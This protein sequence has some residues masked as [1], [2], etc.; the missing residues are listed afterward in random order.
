MDELLPR[1]RINVAAPP[2][3]LASL[4]DGDIDD[5]HLEIGF[6]AGEHLVAN[7]LAHPRRGCIG[8]E[9]FVHGLSRAV[10]D[11]DRLGLG[12]VRLFDDDA[13]FLLDWLP[14]GSIARIELPFPD[15]WPKKRHHKRRFVNA[16]NLDRLARV[17]RPEGALLIATDWP[18][19]AAWS[20][21]RV[22]AHPAFAWTARRP[23]DWREPPSGWASTRY[24]EKAVAA[25]RTST[26]LAFRRV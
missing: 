15:P 10:H 16:T 9:P 24:Q 8:V 13:A 14:A 23:A 20:L 19:Y 22:R 4:F 18:D 5:V 17:L 11:I 6:G 2:P 12:N 25:G 21:G 26:F 3:D 7:A 1:L